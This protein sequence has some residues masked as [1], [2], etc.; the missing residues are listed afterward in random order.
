MA[1]ATPNSG[2]NFDLPM[3]PRP[4]DAEVANEVSK[5]INNGAITFLSDGNVLL[6]PEDHMKYS[7]DERELIK[8]Y[9]MGLNQ[10]RLAAEK[11]DAIPEIKARV[12]GYRQLSQGEM[13]LMNECK[14]ME[15][16]VLELHAKV[17]AHVTRQHLNPPNEMIDYGNGTMVNKEIVR[18]GKAEPDRWLAISKT[19]IQTG[20]MALVRAVAQPE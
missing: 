7:V 8:D 13:D 15:R 5:L 10:K 19:D 14:A 1:I 9:A 4:T 16:Q 6:R 3:R 20:F 17:K 12:S 18:I 2:R 11:R